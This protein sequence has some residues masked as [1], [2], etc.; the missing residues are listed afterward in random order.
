VIASLM[1]GLAVGLVLIH[2]T[3]SF[4]NGMSPSSSISAKP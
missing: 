3:I 4:Q 2:G 1:I